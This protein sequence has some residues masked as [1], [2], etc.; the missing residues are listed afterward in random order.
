MTAQTPAGVLEGLALRVEALG[1]DIVCPL[2]GE[3]DFD[4]PG[5]VNSHMYNGCEVMLA[6]GFANTSA[7][8]AVAIRAQ[9]P[10]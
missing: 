2:C 3:G 4:V 9:A 10:Q 5:F 6:T 8:V 1:C 7:E